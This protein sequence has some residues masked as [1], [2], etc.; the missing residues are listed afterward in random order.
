MGPMALGGQT[1]DTKRCR[2]IIRT[3]T[4]N[5]QSTPGSGH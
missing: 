1:N 5:D 4:T 2:P 3:V